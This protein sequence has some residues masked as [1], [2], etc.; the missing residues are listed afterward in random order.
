M[1]GL[2]AKSI[3]LLGG[4]LEGTPDVL[5]VMRANSSDEIVE[6]LK[7]DPWTGLDLLRT[8]AI[9][10]WVLRLGRLSVSG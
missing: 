5:L 3:V 7:D 8:K 2:E 6:N 4:P 9:T 1:D 10:P